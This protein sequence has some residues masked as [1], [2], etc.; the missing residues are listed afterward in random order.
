VSATLQATDLRFINT[1]A[2]RRFAGADAGRV[3]GDAVAAA[4][5]AAAE[6]TPFARAAALAG[7]LLA[8]QAFATAPLQTGLLVLHCAL[9]LDGFTLVAPQG[10]LAGM[11]GSLARDGDTAAVARWLEDRAVPTASG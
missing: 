4:V 11:I 8:R 10:V 5:A 7:V 3:D 1:V 2:A 6:G 9:S